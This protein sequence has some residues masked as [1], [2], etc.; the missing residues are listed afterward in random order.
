MELYPSV[1][2]RDETSR[3]ERRARAL[4]QNAPASEG[5]FTIHSL[6]LPGHE[7]KRYSEADFLVVDSRGV[8]VL[9]V[10]GGTVK[11]ENG[12]WQFENGRGQ[13][14]TK[15]EGPHQQA[16]S[17]I[18]AVRKMLKNGGARYQP[19]VFGWAV[20]F[21]FTK[22]KDDH[23]EIPGQVVIDE[24]DC[25]DGMS[26]TAAIDRAFAYWKDRAIES[27]RTIYPVD[28]DDYRSTLLPSFQYAPAPA[29][30]AEAIL[31]DV[32]RLSKH[33]C[34][35]VEGFDSNQRLLIEAGAGTGKT[36]LAHA[37]ARKFAGE[38]LRTGFI[39][40]APLLAA[41]LATE[42][43]DVHVISSEELSVIPDD[44]FE[45][46][47]V[48][49]G[50]E[51][52]N[53]SGLE[54][55]DRILEGGLENGRWKWFMDADNQ[56]MKNEVDPD[57]RAKLRNL[58]FYW[59]PPHNVRSTREIVG[60]VKEALGADIGIS[61]IDGR[62]VRP[63]VQILESDDEA[64]KW[65]VEFVAQ[66]TQDGVAPKDIVV[67][68]APSSFDRVRRAME[69][70]PDSELAV[71][72]GPEQFEAMKSRA[73]ISD[74]MTFRGLERAWTVVLCDEAFTQQKNG[75]SHLYVAMTR[76]NAGLAIALGPK[77][78]DWLYAFYE[79]QAGK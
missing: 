8:L 25:A 32:V 49:E 27:G 46:L 72:R 10:K 67:L 79:R 31:A 39:I 33:Q 20:V 65:A 75:E 23:P 14:R 38:R 12:Q 47:V 40:G 34:E 63:W 5:A 56:S 42:L 64:L 59:S 68:A 78:R 60:L 70:L 61:E 28:V 44:A 73:V 19:S 45:V 54:E 50:Q 29:R 30:C 2:F 55:I 16:E 21:P 15:S 62:G 24:G 51:L 26:F 36:V 35:I 37:A 69:W 76:S 11:C 1:I 9:E 17:A 3:G 18:H 41:Q 43:P 77:G 74:P 48:D 58:A 7:Y 4:L 71:V 53:S 57:C 52:V 6:N 13:S 66:K 22:W